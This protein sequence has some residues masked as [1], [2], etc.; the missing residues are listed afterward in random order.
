MVCK[1]FIFRL[2]SGQLDS[3]GFKDRL[4]AA[5]HTLIC[6]KCRQFQKNDRLLSVHLARY[7]QEIEYLEK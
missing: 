7:R 5:A 1:D 2:T 3:A 4:L 6:S